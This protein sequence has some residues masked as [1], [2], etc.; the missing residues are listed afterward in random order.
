MNRLLAVWLPLNQHDDQVGINSGDYIAL[1]F[2]IEDKPRPYIVF[3][4][5]SV[6]H[7]LS[8]RVGMVGQ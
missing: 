5:Q 2:D 8:L 3:S 4:L 1:H 7:L 6:F